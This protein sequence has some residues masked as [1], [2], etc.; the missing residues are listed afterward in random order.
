M[1]LTFE[2]KELTP[3]D[4]NSFLSLLQRSTLLKFA[5][6]YV[7]PHK[8]ARTETHKYK[9][10]KNIFSFFFLA[11]DLYSRHVT[12]NLGIDFFA[13]IFSVYSEVIVSVIVNLTFLF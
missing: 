1:C 5:R 3:S 9:T 11:S 10:K 8:S 7:I 2:E 6:K 4:V 13:T 12:P